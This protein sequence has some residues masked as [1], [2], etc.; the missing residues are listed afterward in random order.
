M[1]NLDAGSDDATAGAS[2]P[3][4]AGEGEG[5]MAALLQEQAV[6]AESLSSGRPTWVRVIQVTREHVLVD[7]GEKREGVIAAAEFSD[8]A[9]AEDESKRRPGDELRLQNSGS[10]GTRPAAPSGK[11]GRPPSG[12]G[13]PLPAGLPAAGQRIPVVLVGRVRQ[14][15]AT[16]LSYRRA[17]EALAW[18]FAQ[19]AF[20]EKARVRGTVT[21]AVKGGFIV[22]LGG[23]R[24][25]LPASLADLRPVREPARLISTGVRC[26][27]IE[28]NAPKKQA[29][30]SRR[31]V[32]E[33]DS[34]KRRGKLLEELRVGEV[35]I[36]RVLKTTPAGLIVDI[37]GAEGFVKS[38]DVAWG[39]PR[40]ASF[41]ARGTRV[42]VKILAKPEAGAADRVVLSMKQLLANPADAL[43]RKFPP[44]AVVRGTVTEAGAAG[45]L[46]KLDDQ[47][48]A[49][50]PPAECPEGHS[51]KAGQ[52][53][54]ALV[55][56]V[57]RDT[58]RLTVSIARFEEIQERKRMSQ[59][60]KSPP[61]L[62]LGQLLSPADSGEE[63]SGAGGGGPPSPR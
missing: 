62:T 32:L 60:L 53:V 1:T 44:R 63:D 15:A 28:L 59:Y 61:P 37:G 54:S 31:A 29:V 7:I 10:A 3:E 5:G 13:G 2:G 16:Q 56:G 26:Y 30:L 46:L 27:I 38:A 42:K 17:R 47:T 36:G 49:A 19:K 57:D 55:L 51:L 4:D 6:A 34:L 24:A 58:L 35:R 52:A 41:P 12:D 18:D 39:E 43:R 23:L 21:A 9:A 40:P 8:S 33:E 50:C 22:D 25:F 20:T 14:D 45:I 48:P 11:G